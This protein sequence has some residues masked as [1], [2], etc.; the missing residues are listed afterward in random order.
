[1]WDVDK[2]YQRPVSLIK[3]DGFTVRLHTSTMLYYIEY[4]EDAFCSSFIVLEDGDISPQI[5]MRSAYHSVLTS[6]A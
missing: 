6:M 5:I 1:M 2:T 4:T 3:I